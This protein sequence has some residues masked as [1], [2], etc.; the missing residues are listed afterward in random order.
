MGSHEP[1]FGA[2]AEW[3]C[4]P[5]PSLGCFISTAR[6]GAQFLLIKTNLF[7]LGLCRKSAAAHAGAAPQT[8]E[9]EIKTHS[10]GKPK[11]TANNVALPDRAEPSRT[12]RRYWIFSFFS[13]EKRTPPG[14]C[15]TFYA[16]LIAANQI[17]QSFQKETSLTIE[18]SSKCDHCRALLLYKPTDCVIF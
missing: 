8:T 7:F 4:W 10:P 13:T 9:L 5:G 18:C 6:L 17:V 16:A 2:Q 1:I 15:F 12:P 11:H 3:G 14:F